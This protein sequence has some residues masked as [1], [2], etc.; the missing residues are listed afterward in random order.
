MNASEIAS[1]LKEKVA[2]FREFP[3]ERLQGLVEGSRVGS[4]EAKEAVMHL[5][6]EAT[7]FGVVLSGTVNASALGDGGVI[8]LF[9]FIRRGRLTQPVPL[10]EPRGISSSW[11]CHPLDGEH[12]TS[13]MPPAI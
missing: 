1:L 11:K 3:A 12:C 8:K 6:A 5:G 2:P 9:S 7:H 10:P 4:F 13:D